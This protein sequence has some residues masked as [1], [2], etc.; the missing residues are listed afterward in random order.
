LQGI[1]EPSLSLAIIIIDD[2]RR[3][4]RIRQ[5]ERAKHSEIVLRGKEVSRKS[6]AFT[7][8]REEKYFLILWISGLIIKKGRSVWNLASRFSLFLEY[9]NTGGGNAINKK[10]NLVAQIRHQNNQP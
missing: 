1:E 2:A 7:L 5:T 3:D 10:A 4:P 8:Y 9:D 6:S